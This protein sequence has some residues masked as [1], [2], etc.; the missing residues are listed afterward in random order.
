MCQEVGVVIVGRKTFNQYYKDVFPIKGVINVVLTTEINM[1]IEYTNIKS[2]NSVQQAVDYLQSHQIKQ[3]IMAG[4]GTLNA[5][6]LRENKISELIVVV[7]PLILGAG[8][9]LFENIEL[10]KHLEFLGS[11]ELGEGLVQLHYNVLN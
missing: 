2:V 3:A 8:V 4:G 10:E 5:S 6:F 1:P 7:H 11:V 9:K